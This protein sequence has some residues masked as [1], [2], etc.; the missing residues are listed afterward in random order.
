M[1]IGI[2]NIGI[3]SKTCCNNDFYNV[4]FNEIGISNTEYHSSL[5]ERHLTYTAYPFLLTPTH[6]TLTEYAMLCTT[7]PVLFTE[8]H[9]SNTENHFL[10]TEYPFLSTESHFQYTSNRRKQR[11]PNLPKAPPVRMDV[12]EEKTTILSGYYATNK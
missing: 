4:H 12:N 7:H 11:M 8:D 2:E 10:F 6:K 9:F 5:I 1:Y 3:M